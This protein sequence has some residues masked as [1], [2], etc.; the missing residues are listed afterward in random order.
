MPTSCRNG[1]STAAAATPLYPDIQIVAKRFNLPQLRRRRRIAVL[2]PW[3][4]HQTDRHYPVLYLQDGQNLFEDGASFGTWGVDK[5]IAALA[6][7]G[8][9]TLSS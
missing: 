8:K 3:N 2:L 6:Q 1:N 5:K 9:A 4:Y 7:K